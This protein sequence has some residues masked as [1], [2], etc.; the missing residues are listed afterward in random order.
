MVDQVEQEIYTPG[1]WYSTVQKERQG[2]RL[3]VW[4]RGGFRRRTAA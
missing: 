3:G 1:T 2:S 4:V